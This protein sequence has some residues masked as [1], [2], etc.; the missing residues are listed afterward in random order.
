LAAF[1][2]LDAWVGDEINDLEDPVPSVDFDW[3]ALAPKNTGN[4]WLETGVNIPTWFWIKRGYRNTQIHEGGSHL[5]WRPLGPS[6]WCL[7]DGPEPAFSLDESYAFEVP[8]DE[9]DGVDPNGPLFQLPLPRFDFSS[10]GQPY[11]VPSGPN[12]GESAFKT[13]IVSTW[14]L[15]GDLDGLGPVNM[16]VPICDTQYVWVRQ[17]QSILARPGEPLPEWMTAQ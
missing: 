14:H 15:T 16:P 13:T 17:V 12:A 6:A 1:C 9:V 5:Y 11:R 7:G 3:R 2:D 10:L 4:P 8:L